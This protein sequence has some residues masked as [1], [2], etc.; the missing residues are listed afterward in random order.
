MRL[1]VLFFLVFVIACISATPFGWGHPPRGISRGGRHP[2]RRHHPGGCGP[3]TPPHDAT[4][5][6]DE[7]DATTEEPEWDQ[8]DDSEETTVDDVD[9]TSEI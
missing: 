3:T 5:E 1:S 6:A 7:D 4:T 2:I 8:T 9:V